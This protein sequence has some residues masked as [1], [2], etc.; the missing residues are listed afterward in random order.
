LAELEAVA[1]VEERFTKTL[2]RDD[3]IGEWRTVKGP[4]APGIVRLSLGADLVILGQVLDAPEDVILTCR[5]PVLV[6][7]YAGR[8]NR[9]GKYVLIAWNGSREARRAL[10]DALP[11]M[12]MSKS[13]T[14]LAANADA[15]QRKEIEGDLTPHLLRHGLHIRS[16][17]INSDLAVSDTLLSRAADQA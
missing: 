16:E 15:E 7:P 1:A 5:C 13:V 12:S 9:I 17:L 2:Q 10:R 4:A 8:F 3:L 11:L 6:V 14:V